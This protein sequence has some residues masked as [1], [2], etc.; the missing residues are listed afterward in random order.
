MTLW[1]Y[2]DMRFNILY[3]PAG[4]LT[5]FTPAFALLPYNPTRVI[6]AGNG[7]LAYLF[8]PQTTG[9][10]ASLLVFN[11]SGTVQST[12][13]AKTLFN[14]LPF[15]SSKTTKSFM[16]IADKDGITVLSGDCSESAAGLEL[17]SFVAGSTQGNGTWTSLQMA[18][19]D[20]SL[21]ANYL[22]A[23]F[24]FSP[25]S[26]AD[27]ASLYVFGGMCPNSKTESA[28]TWT[29]N[30]MYTNTMLTLSPEAA[31]SS[32]APYQLSV[33]GARAPPIAEAGLTITALTPASSDSNGDQQQNFVLIG[34][35]TQQAFINM[36]QV[37]LF[38]LPQQS[39]A[40][41]AV[42][43]PATPVD[44]R[45]G[46]TAVLTEDGSKII[47]YGG[48]VGDVSTPAQPQLAVLNIGEGYG[49]DGDWS[50]TLPSQ[51]SSPYGS[52]SGVY[53]HG[54][55]LLPG[56]VMMV[57]GGTQINGGESKAKRGSP[58]DMDFFNTTSMTWGNTYINPNSPASP[59][60]ISHPADSTTDL[61]KTDR[62]GLGV[63]LALGL[64]AL[65]GIAV[66][67]FLYSRRL[68]QQ[69]AIREKELRE[70]ALGTERYHSTSFNAEQDHRY[71]ERRSASWHNMQERQME[72]SGAEAYPWAPVINQDQANRLNVESDQDEGNGLRQAERTGLLFDIPSPTRGLRRSMHSRGP[73]SFG[74]FQPA[75]SGV[76]GG[77]FRIDEE[78][79]GSR[80][81][82]LRRLR[83]PNA[84]ID[85]SSTHSDPFKD[86]PKT[87]ESISEEEAERRK[88]EVQ[89]WVEDWQE[90][91]ESMN[92][93]RSPSQAHSRTYSNLS[94]AYSQ[95]HSSSSD[96]SGRGS[97]EKSDR[98]GSNLS[99]RSQ[100][101]QASIQKS[102]AGTVSRN[103]SQ[104]SASA[105][106]ALFSGAAAAIGR[107]TGRPQQPDYGTTS[108]LASAPSVRS[109]SLN[110]HPV[111]GRPPTRERAETIS[112]A[113]TSTV[114]VQPGE[115]SALLTRFDSLHRY[116]GDDAYWT[117]PQ[118]P[119]K[120]KKEYRSS[121]LTRTGVKA[122]GLLGSVRRVFTGTGGVDVSDRVATFEHSAGS[123][124]TKSIP[125][126]MESTPGRSPS[127]SQAFWRG[128]R[129][130]KD[131]QTEDDAK[132][133][134][135]ASNT[136][137]IRRK[138]LPGQAR[139]EDWDVESAVNNRVVQVMFTVPKEKLRVVNAD[140]LS[141]LSSN[142]SDVDH[143]EE[144]D[145]EREVK[146][147]SSVRE[148]DEDVQ[149]DEKGKQPV[150]D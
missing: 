101:S 119:V 16:P 32:G 35:H 30:A 103:T 49:G 61:K 136:G 26:S 74:A 94:Q 22:S 54:A 7:S 144:K 112:G 8:A 145:R 71:P 96:P 58:S 69:R 62:I 115:K 12:D 37:A 31:S 53:G 147:M 125:E 21:G 78:E 68:R 63:G 111:T 99:E 70:L 85:R 122:M 76:P 83:A 98:T 20:Q 39:W 81:G 126:M 5:L 25:D 75:P 27:A 67:W 28:S 132:D 130:A 72:S 117:P 124:P 48:W 139:D 108:N 34:G 33:T 14:A 55:V 93:S 17:W 66:V 86:P 43:Q 131:W 102:A 4:L 88:K 106:Y 77:V 38:A 128:K 116:A 23:G 107:M 1:Y 52:G 2:D 44:P 141:L 59:A 80:N 104:R 118:S 133:S 11:T 15:L 57:T 10:Q 9:S 143:E 138:P 18:L 150:R 109:F 40:F 24:S 149:Y 6:G 45:S 105:G 113:K 13:H 127:A 3:L 87:A 36:S 137:T 97:P 79:E 148:G 123:S 46:H 82:S 95:Y 50:W 51:S 129:G 114:P 56:G 41:A 84:I 60:Y 120:D 29:S 110:S 92:I 135:V 73:Q 90:A 64:I 140:A 47:V 65:A 19:D 42:D 89:G 91:A 134:A 100:Y 142:R 121:S 146:R